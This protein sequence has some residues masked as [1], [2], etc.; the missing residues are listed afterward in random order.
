MIISATLCSLM[1]LPSVSYAQK[2]PMGKFARAAMKAMPRTS[3]CHSLP[4]RADDE[5]PTKTVVDQHFDKWTAGTNAEPDTKMLGG[6]S[7]N[8]VLPADLMG[9]KG[10]TG[11]EVYQAGQACALRMYESEYGGL[12]GGFISTPEMELSGDVVLKFRA[13]CLKAGDEGVIRVALCDNNEG[14]VDDRDFDISDQW[15][16]FTFAT[17]QATFNPNNI[18]QFSAEEVDL[19]LDDIVVTRK[20]NKIPAP[21]V[22][23]PVNNSSTS[24][25]ARWSPTT[26][27]SSYLLNVYRKEMPEHCVE[28][29]SLSENFG[30]FR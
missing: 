30:F 16:E 8:Y 6:G 25:T 29:G 1:L 19:L 10:W 21:Q 17:D 4:N 23:Q 15:Q 12:A 24:F 5:I 3:E 7:V 22:L 20:A 14:P 18:F 26:T 27:A 28:P 2:T 9:T 11:N 13:R